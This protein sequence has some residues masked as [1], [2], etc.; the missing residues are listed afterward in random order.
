MPTPYTLDVHLL[1]G[2]DPRRLVFQ[3]LAPQLAV[4]LNAPRLVDLAG[5]RL[6]P[7]GRPSSCCSK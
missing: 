1:A 7:D 6:A 2:H 5:A 4:P 3:P